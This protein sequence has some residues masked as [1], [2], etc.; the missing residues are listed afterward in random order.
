M[1]RPGRARTASAWHRKQMADL[2]GR[3]H[4]AFVSLKKELGHEACRSPLLKMVCSGGIA[5]P[6]TT[7]TDILAA[8]RSLLLPSIRD[9]GQ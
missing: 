2:G 4:L 8:R 7:N 9:L 1:G 5:R 6:A 3:G